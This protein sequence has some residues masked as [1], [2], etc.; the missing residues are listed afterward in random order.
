MNRAS[1]P[2]P[3]T[4]RRTPSLPAALEA[5]Q[6]GDVHGRPLL[7][8]ILLAALGWSLLQVDGQSGL[9]RASGGSVLLEVGRG[10]LHPDFS[11]PVLR[12][13]ARAA[14]ATLVYALAGMSV[15][16]ALGLPLG[17][18]AS[19]VLF[20]RRL[21][22]ALVAATRTLLAAL[23]AVHELVWAWLFVAA[24][25]L[26]P[27]A[28]VLALALPY[29]GILGR[30]Y[31]DLLND[32]GRAPLAALTTA[33]ADR[34]QLLLYGHLPMAAPDMTAYT[35]YRFECALRSSAVMGFVGLGGLGFQIQI[36][37]A[38]LRWGAVA[39]ALLALVALIAA[40]EAWSAVVRRALAPGA[41]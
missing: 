9:L 3:R 24:L 18:V 13:T 35:F 7:S 25:G 37:L 21:R 20:G 40:V 39:T 11:A 27:L 5:L 26:S 38:D 2:A 29:A 31:A 1:S 41:V 17:V 14:W 10:L 12:A 36:A 34:S 22:P 23:R 30:I 28:G 16:V 19:G 15:A 32:V 6:L 4:P 33:G 8:L